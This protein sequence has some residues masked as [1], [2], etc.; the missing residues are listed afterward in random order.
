MAIIKHIAN[1]N[2]NYREAIDYMKYEY[3]EHSQKP[4]PDKFGNLR[5]RDEFILEGINCNPETF[6]I[7][8]KKLNKSYNK[9]QRYDEIKSHHYIIS[10]DPLDQIDNG[11]T[12]EKAQALGMEFTRKHFPGHQAIVCTHTDGHNGSGNIHVHIVINSLRKFDVAPQDFME[13]PCDSRAGCKH[14]LTKD[15]LIC[16]KKSLMEMCIRE[17]LNQVD[18]LTDSEAKISEQEY[19]AAHRGQEK[20][21][22]LNDE[23]TANGLTPMETKFQTQKQFLRDAIDDISSY[24]TSPEMFREELQKNYHISLTESRGRYSYLHPDRSKNITGRALGTRYEK[25]FL[26]A[27][28]EEN[29][30]LAEILQHE[31]LTNAE[32]R[33]N[34]KETLREDMP[35]TATNEK[36]IFAESNGRRSTIYDSSYDYENDPV[37]ILYIHSHLRLVVNLQEGV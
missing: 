9:N 26:L 12:K 1:K 7:E 16:L 3:D 33:N 19:W 35:K 20:L 31:Q 5:L 37:A 32:N 28:F 8:C 10:F 14:H 34:K 11:L 17:N 15:Y 21:D 13:R 22:K 24:A 2:A 29:I 27:R 25:E 30:K 18:L 36:D 6:D 4:L 23:I